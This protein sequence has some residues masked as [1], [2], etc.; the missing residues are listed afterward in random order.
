MIG[1]E[2]GGF[3][4]QRGDTFADESV[5]ISLETS[6]SLVRDPA[7]VLGHFHLFNPFDN[8]QTDAVGCGHLEE[9]RVEGEA[10]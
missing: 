1:G 8:L 3:L 4:A 5:Q 9:A 2:P 7:S 6:G 10:F